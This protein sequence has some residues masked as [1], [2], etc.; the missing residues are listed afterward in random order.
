MTSKKNVINK[1]KIKIDNNVF[2]ESLYFSEYGYGYPE[3]VYEYKKGKIC[4]TSYT[5][6]ISPLINI[7]DNAKFSKCIFE[8]I[9]NW[10]HKYYWK[11]FT[12][13][14]GTLWVL[15]IK[16]SNGK[17]LK[18]EGHQMFPD[19]YPKLRGYLNRFVGKYINKFQEEYRR[20]GY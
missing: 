5:G 20:Y 14:D 1:L 8:I 4:F 3:E 15:R 11:E 10:K 16:L 19:N 18:Y 17:Y 2:I 6:G 13:C 12:I 7:R 9:E